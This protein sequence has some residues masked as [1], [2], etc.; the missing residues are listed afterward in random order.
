MNK[1]TPIGIRHWLACFVVVLAGATGSLGQ[2]PSV[3]PGVSGYRVSVTSDWVACDQ[4]YR[5]I[6]VTIDTDPAV[7]VVEDERFTVSVTRLHYSS[8]PY[9]VT[10]PI[11]IP[12]GANS[13]SVEL[14]LQTDML[15]DTYSSTILVERG[16]YDGSRDR[17]DLFS[18]D[19]PWDNGYALQPTILMIS[20][21][22]SE[23]A[24]RSWVCYR[25]NIMD[26]G[27]T[28]AAYG[29]NRP[30]PSFDVLD[31]VC[32][33]SANGQG[34][35]GVPPATGVSPAT[36][37]RTNIRLGGVHPDFIPENWIGLTGIEQIIVSLDDL[38][39]ICTSQARNRINLEKWVV[40]GGTMIVT[41]TGA[42]F[43]EANKILPLLLGRN[44]SVVAD[45]IVP[46]WKVPGD[47]LRKLNK[48]IPDENRSANYY[49]ASPFWFNVE[50]RTAFQENLGELTVFDDLSSN[51][52]GSKFAVSNYLNGRIV[53]VKGDMSSWRKT[54]W[55]IL[56]NTIVLAGDNIQQRIGRSVSATVDSEFRIPGVGEPPVRMFQIL[57]SLFLF[58]AGPVMLL[59]LKKTEQ[60]QYMFVAVPCLSVAICVSLLMYAVL[61]DGSKRWGR[62]QS[63]T[64]MDHRTNMAV[65]HARA[66][67]Y[68]GRRPGPYDFRSDT[69]AKTSLG[70]S[71]GVLMDRFGNGMH[72]LS[73]GEI[74]PRNPHE[75]VTVRSQEAKQRLILISPGDDTGTPMIDNRLG[76]HVQIALIRTRDG[77]F[78]LED[79]EPEQRGQAQKVSPVK[80]KELIGKTIEILSPQRLD[81]TNSLAWISPYS[82]EYGEEVRF[83]NELRIADVDEFLVE[84][85]TY[86]ALMEQFPLAA[87]QL[88]PVQYKMQLHVVRGKW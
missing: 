47:A 72:E 33:L 42:K 48:L 54:D 46:Q 67:Y 38:R 28:Q 9:V 69:L 12:T 40:A 49:Q 53:A 4:G 8:G 66:T 36:V 62:S 74:R 64:T 51:A 16:N 52:E 3:P 82:I 44:R 23:P 32:R 1:R 63:V 73:G 18:A 41:E 56:L 71:S 21:R 84:P 11:V 19:F 27:K 2:A 24:F 29:S 79:L 70:E 6:R 60:M 58:L 34:L 17:V 57:I 80:A 83:V 81:G 15:N 88:E 30:L 87:E 85:N 76:G 65:T 39:L 77:L 26:A 35:T 59:V 55:R 14:Y 43:E 10:A 13:A 37:F 5:P 61:V 7:A 86:V 78:L 50:E 25:D 75:V 20:S 22:F 68:S 45:R 31:D